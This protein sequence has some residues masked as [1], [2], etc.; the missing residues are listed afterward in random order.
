MLAQLIMKKKE[1]NDVDGPWCIRDR[2]L[3]AVTERIH[4]ECF[5]SGNL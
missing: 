1:M 2:E 5:I 3:E 4:R